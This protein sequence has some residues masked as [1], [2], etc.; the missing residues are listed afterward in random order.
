MAALL[1]AYIALAVTRAVLD[2]HVICGQISYN[3][4][5]TQALSQIWLCSMYRTNSMVA[6]K[7]SLYESCERVRVASYGGEGKHTMGH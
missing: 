1:T 4:S 2:A 5:A 3:K 7:N 6:S